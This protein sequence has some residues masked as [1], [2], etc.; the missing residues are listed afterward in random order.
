M[1]LTAPPSHLPDPGN[2]T[3]EDRAHAV[4]AILAAGLLRLRRPVG[5]AVG[6]ALPPPE[7]LSASLA[8]RLAEPGEK[9]VT[10]TAG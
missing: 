9:S 3:P 4:P 5:P 8:N 1:P 7:N 6:P 2:D 10:V